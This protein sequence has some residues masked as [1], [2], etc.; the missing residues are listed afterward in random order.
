MEKARNWRK[1]GVT[2]EAEI[3]GC[4]IKKKVVMKNRSYMTV[5]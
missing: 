3:V 5:L 1:K 4:P 2:D